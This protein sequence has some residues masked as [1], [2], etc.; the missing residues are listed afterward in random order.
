MSFKV[1]LA[2]LSEILNAQSTS[3]LSLDS[4]P[5]RIVTDTR[6]ISPGDIFLAFRGEKFDGH[7]YVE[8]AIANGASAAIVSR[9][10]ST[11]KEIPQLIVKDT[12]AA[13]QA[14]SKWWRN[15]LKIPVVAITGSA[16]K[17]TTKEIIAAVL[18]TL[19]SVHKTQA[20]FNNEIGVP[21]TLLEI[22]SQHQ[23]AVIEMGMRG[24]GEIGLLTDIARP[25]IGV[26]TN[27]GTAHIGRLGSEQGIA[28]AKCEL[29]EQ[30]PRDSIAILN[31]DNQR[32]MDTA[33]KVWQGETISYG[34]EN[35]NFIGKLIDS[36]T[37]RVEGMDLPLP[38]PGYHNA[39]NYLAALAVAKV[40]GMELSSFSQGVRVELPEGR[41]Q[42]YKL[43]NDLL[44]LDETY[45]ASPESTIASL[46]LLKE[47][48]GKRYL[49]VLGTMKELGELSR[50]LH[51]QV[52]EKVK[53]LGLDAL[54]VL[55]DDPETEEIAKGARGIDTETF[56]DR[57]LLIQRLVEVVRPGDRLLF[58][59]SH[60]VGLDRVLNKFRLIMGD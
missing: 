57:D 48:P 49:A 11:S 2:L 42:K 52:G 14:I 1:S 31:A 37:I 8:V 60:S 12:L 15:S 9:S 32:L 41:S 43:D 18:A 47:T 22:N 13:Y 45:N 59:A 28:E 34:L 20:N 17:T 7:D 26:I 29:L 4:L 39:L 54:F 16:G 27:V 5:T 51:L 46:K 21:K 36:N 40:L 44:I 23:F 35:G 25:N 38:L 19:G 50:S 53:E 30:M 58:K 6:T 10:V 24:R 3:A 33:V 55:I 56:D